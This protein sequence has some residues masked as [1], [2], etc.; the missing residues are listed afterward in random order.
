MLTYEH[1]KATDWNK[2]V[3]YVKIGYAQMFGNKYLR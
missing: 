2:P 1:F 3:D